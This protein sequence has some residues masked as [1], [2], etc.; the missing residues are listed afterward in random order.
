MRRNSILLAGI[1]SVAC[2]GTA[3]AQGSGWYLGLGAGWTTLDPVKFNIAPPLGPLGGDTTF[4][5][6]AAVYLAGGYRFDMPFRVEGEI[7]YADFSSSR[8][9]IGSASAVSSGDVGMTSFLING[10]YDFPLSR[11]FSLSLGAGV[12]AA[13]VDASLHDGLGDR[14]DRSGTA[15]TYQGIVGFNVGLTEQLEMGVDYRY[16]FVDNSD[17][18]LTTPLGQADASLKTQNI[19]SVM[20]NVRWF[21]AGPPPPPPPPPA[22]YVPPPP[23]PP[24]PPPAPVKTFIV[25]FDFDKSDLT[26]EAVK[27]VAEAANTAKTAGMV[28]V[29]VTGHTDTTGSV[30]YNQALS[31]RRAVAVKAQLVT[32][33]L[34]DADISTVG[35]G[36][37]QPLVATGPGVREPQ[38]RRAVIDLGH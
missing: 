5:D 14:L 24:P 30:S 21:L 18:R 37:S 4:E 9:R 22:P 34:S 1:L 10:L 28:K 11:H 6:G 26:D 3:A 33:G 35:K 38:N 19:Q 8:L 16:Q 32:D 27:V 7:H 12:G 15:F 31:E 25:F 29:L 17:H 13:L 23:P 20:F 36:F 2:A